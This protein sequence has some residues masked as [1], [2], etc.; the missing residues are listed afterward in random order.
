[1]I[2]IRQRFHIDLLPASGHAAKVTIPPEHI[3]RDIGDE[4][5]KSHGENC[6]A[7]T[8]RFTPVQPFA[9]SFG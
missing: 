7:K 1:M 8:G 2:R 4:S 9:E 6:M 5:A 3:T